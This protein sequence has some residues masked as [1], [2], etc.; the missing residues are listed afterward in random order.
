MKHLCSTSLKKGQ[1]NQEMNP[2]T[3]TTHTVQIL[4]HK[5]Y[6]GVLSSVFFSVS[7]LLYFH[8]TNIHYKS[9][10]AILMSLSLG[11]TEAEWV[12]QEN[13]LNLDFLIWKVLSMLIMNQ[14]NCV[15]IKI[16]TLSVSDCLW[17]GHFLHF[18]ILFRKM[19]YFKN[20]KLFQV[21]FRFL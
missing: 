19:Q 13:S 8:I 17:I 9:T 5:R 11:A 6:L 4:I 7:F 15:K 14:H 10:T 3:V 1:G 12:S 16:K 2:M 20:D 21:I 18:I